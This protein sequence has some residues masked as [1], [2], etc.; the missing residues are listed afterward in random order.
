MERPTEV[1]EIKIDYICDYVA[2]KSQADVEWLQNFVTT[3]ITSEETGK[4]RQPTFIDI[5]KA[6]VERYMPELL[7]KKQSMYTQ[8][9]ALKFKGQ[10]QEQGEQEPKTEQ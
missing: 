6:F 1:K 7:S 3:K 10:P 2:Q 8:I 5:R 9:A 4:S